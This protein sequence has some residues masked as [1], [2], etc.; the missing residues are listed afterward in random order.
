MM[1]VYNK[2]I[3][4]KCDKFGNIKE[5]NILLEKAETIKNLKEKSLSK[6][7]VI[8]ETDK[9]NEFSVMKT[10]SYEKAMEEHGNTTV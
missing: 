6:D 9:S 3:V 10:D 4:E 8:T 2:F 7:V 1:D 5:N